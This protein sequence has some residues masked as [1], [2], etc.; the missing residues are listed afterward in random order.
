MKGA[1]KGWNFARMLS[2]DGSTTHDALMAEKNKLEA[3]VVAIPQEIAANE[4][5]IANMQKDYD[6][7]SSLS[8]SRQKDYEKEHGEHPH[9]ASYRLLNQINAAKAKIEALKG[10]KSRIAVRLEELNKQLDALVKGE[11]DG[12]SKGLDKESAKALGEIELQKQQTQLAYDTKLREIEVA[13]AE[14]QA[15]KEATD[16]QKGKNTS[17]IIGIAIVAILAIV[18]Y[19]IYRSRKAKALAD[20]ATVQ[21]LKL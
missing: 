5:S 1:I 15:A 20:V 3:R 4:A 12:L 7:L 21:P 18:G 14:K 10:E 13:Q 2:A 8:K 11:S 19:L 9:Q 17:L 6:W 16:D